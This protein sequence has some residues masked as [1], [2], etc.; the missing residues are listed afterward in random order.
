MGILITISLLPWIVT[1]EE[2]RPYPKAQ[3]SN[4]AKPKGKSC[5]LTDTPKKKR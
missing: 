5:N 2:V 4:R 1:P 3:L